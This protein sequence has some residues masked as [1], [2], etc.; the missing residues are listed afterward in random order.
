MLWPW[1]FAAFRDIHA[2]FSIP[3]LAQSPDIGQNSEGR[4][5]ISGFQVNPL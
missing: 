2:K 1:H 3:N 5:S 4:I